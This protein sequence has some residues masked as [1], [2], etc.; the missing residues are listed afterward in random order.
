MIVHDPVFFFS[1]L[2]INPDECLTDIEITEPI[3]I[4]SIPE[5]SSTSA[6]GSDCVPSSLLLNCAAELA[7]T[8]KLLLIIIRIF[9]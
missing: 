9:I 7:Q 2:S 5:L 1:Y 8:L 6:T 4:D 3:I